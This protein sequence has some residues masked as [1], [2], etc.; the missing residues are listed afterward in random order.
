[1][2]VDFEFEINCPPG[3][4]KLSIAPSFLQP[5]LG[6]AIKHGI[7]A[8]KDGKGFIR[9]SFLE[10]RENY[11]LCTIEDNG[12]EIKETGNQNKAITKKIG[13]MYLIRERF[14]VFN[15]LYKTNLGFTISN[16]DPENNFKGVIISIKVPA[17]N[18]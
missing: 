17:L 2:R 3:L 16:T 14:R 6:N 18:T 1:M 4:E 15:S 12:P 13:G 11:L 7:S 9:L 8:R 5:F 10:H